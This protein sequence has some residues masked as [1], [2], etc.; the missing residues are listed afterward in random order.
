MSRTKR[1]EVSVNA[2][3]R[4]VAKTRTKSAMPP[5]IAEAESG[6]ISPVFVDP[7]GQHEAPGTLRENAIRLYHRVTMSWLQFALAIIPIYEGRLYERF[8]FEDDVPKRRQ[9][10]N[11]R[12]GWSKYTEA[13]FPDMT[14][15]RIVRVMRAAQTLKSIRPDIVEQLED[16]GVAQIPSYESLN[17]LG[18]LSGGAKRGEVSQEKCD[19]VIERAFSGKLSGKQIIAEVEEVWEEA[20]R[21]ADDSR[22]VKAARDQTPEGS[23]L[24][25]SGEQPSPGIVVANVPEKPEVE[26]PGLI[27]ADSSDFEA[28]A[29]ESVPSFDQAATVLIDGL[30]SGAIA[31][32][33]ALAR[34]ASDASEQY[35]IPFDDAV[36]NLQC[37]H[38][39]VDEV[40]ERATEE[41]DGERICFL[42]EKLAQTLAE[43]SRHQDFQTEAA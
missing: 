3:H 1:T 17:R 39:A 25:A 41:N 4:S 33:G 43:W 42:V 14:A 26:Q 10:G 28:C 11:V 19:K 30:S 12:T 29:G 16:A 7:Q 5:P 6:P 24:P 18:G 21:P 9:R 22:D 40:F 20:R 8:G 13:D 27:V 37:I 31:A 23:G 2:E 36:M 35:W 32:K 15:H 38:T 34:I